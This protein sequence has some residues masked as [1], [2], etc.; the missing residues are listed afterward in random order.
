MTRVLRITIALQIFFLAPLSSLAQTPMI[1]TKDPQALAVAQA[2]L[3]AMGGPQAF[4][5]IRTLWRA[6]RLQS[7]AAA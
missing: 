4:V 1:A 6:G 3:A 7:T 5:F 2:A